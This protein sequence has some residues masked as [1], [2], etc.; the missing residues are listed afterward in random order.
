M[1]DKFKS[2]RS[3]HNYLET[4]AQDLE[5]YKISSFF[6]IL[7]DYYRD[8][9]KDKLMMKSHWEMWFWDFVIDEGVLHPRVSG[10]NQ[11]GSRFEYPSLN[12]FTSE[13]YDL[14]INK[15]ANTNNFHIKA[16]YGNLLW[17]SPKK[18]KQYA[19]VSID[20][21]IILYEYLLNKYAN[22][23]ELI[24]E[25]RLI[26]TIKNIFF[27]SKSVKYKTDVSLDIIYKNTV[28]YYFNNGFCSGVRFD[29]IEIII[30]YKLLKTKYKELFNFCLKNVILLLKNNQNINLKIQNLYSAI[31][32]LKKSL[33][34]AE[35]L[36]KEIIVFQLLADCY[37]KLA[38]LEGI[39][40]VSLKVDHFE[41]SLIYYKKI[42]NISKIESLKKIIDENKKNVEL[43]SAGIKINVK[44][45]LKRYNNILRLLLKDTSQNIYR[46]LQNSKILFPDETFVKNEIESMKKNAPLTYLAT[47]QIIDS[48]GNKPET[49]TAEERDLYA[50]WANYDYAFHT[51]KTYFIEKI[52]IECIKSKKITYD[53][54][55]DFI[56]NYTWFGKHLVKKT[57]NSSPIKYNWLGSIYPSLFDF[58][59]NMDLWLKDSRFYPNVVLSVDS[60]TLK[61]EG[62]FRDLCNI[63]NIP[64]FDIKLDNNGE[65]T[66][67]E[68]DINALLRDEDLKKLFELEE[69]NF[70]KYLLIE[71]IGLNLRNNIA[72]CFLLPPYYEV[73][74]MYY[75]IIV[76]LIIG[77]YDYV[78]ENTDSK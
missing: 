51:D 32:V 23:K 20:N 78:K 36:K 55:V 7:R 70:F 15:F 66:T 21:Y 38:E 77:K 76:I 68:K 53:S 12:D 6:K 71:K 48:R 75:L 40:S 42:K 54:L 22:T 69:I 1:E 14:L 46:F 31:T 58:F 61:I 45:V 63:K 30:K 52:F 5:D 26:N 64:T 35:K 73:E 47:S 4:S 39:R 9:K 10:I 72:H 19:I 67:K 29:L 65:T 44:N 24:D 18:H 49:F 33:Y 74:Y 60:L 16:H 28:K 3:L 17:L 37:E 27:L 8:K 56:K 25:S 34:F 11:D 57:P 50:Y 62:L 41:N 2:L 59:I 43:L 13:I